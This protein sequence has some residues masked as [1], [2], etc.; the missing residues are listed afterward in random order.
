[1]TGKKGSAATNITPAT[2]NRIT[3]FST[4]SSSNKYLGSLGFNP[5]DTPIDVP[6][7]NGLRQVKFLPIKIFLLLTLQKKKFCVQVKWCCVKI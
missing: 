1:M 3:L 7:L 6:S 4:P 2:A 5:S